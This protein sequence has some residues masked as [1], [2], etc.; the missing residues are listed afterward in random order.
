MFL[1]EEDGVAPDPE[2][3][4]EGALAC[5]VSPAVEGLGERTVVDRI[6]HLGRP[7]EEVHLFVVHEE[8]LVKQADLLEDLSMNQQGA[9]Q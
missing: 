9:A 2:R 1:E 6:A 8:G 7:V 4:L 3:F 5:R